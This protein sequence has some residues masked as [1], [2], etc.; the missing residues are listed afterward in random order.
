M[1]PQT[2]RKNP[3]QTKAKSL[4]MNK[5]VKKN[6][7]TQA[8]PW[9]QEAYNSKRLNIDLTGKGMTS[10]ILRPQKKGNMEKELDKW[11]IKFSNKEEEDQFA[12]HMLSNMHQYPFAD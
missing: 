2:M 9:T 1:N 3:V 4:N 12:R 7:K 8:S 5:N 10:W 6:T 11:E